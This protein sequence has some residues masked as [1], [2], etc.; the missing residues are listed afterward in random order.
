[1]SDP[2]HGAPELSV[3]VPFLDEEQSVAPFFSELFGVLDA[4]GR[5]A[6][7][8]AVDDGS[9]DQT[10][11]RLREAREADR[12]LRV[13]R[14][15]RNFGQSAALAAGFEHSRGSIIITLDGDQ[16][17]D[18][19]EIPRL[20]EKIDEGW[21]VVSGWRRDREDSL[22]MRI[23]PSKVANWIIARVTGVP[24]HDYGCALKVYRAEITEGIRLY[25]EMHR[26]LPTLA[27][28]LGASVTELPVRHRPR[29]TGRSK[30]GL[31]RTVR[32]VLD[33][34]TVR[35]LSSYATRPLQFFGVLG[36][37]PFLIGTVTLAWLG[38]ERIFL[39]AELG[40]RP[41]VLLAIVL[42]IT[43]LQF[44]TFGLL[45]EMMARTYHESQ[46]KPVYIVREVL[47]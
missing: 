11:D 38:F 21:D 47:E 14:F 23:L 45:A 34:L 31:S 37:P 22:A 30:Y 8:V 12:R 25:G 6:E 33:L 39:G 40:G 29:T 2:N 41:L 3:V 16:Q 15:R 9:T 35:F 46:N 36:A 27:A 44:L 20:L 4:T 43:G 18:P 32:V 10:F 7:V 42:V 26:F 24:L 13:V 5:A 17:N 19:T 1:M 28:D